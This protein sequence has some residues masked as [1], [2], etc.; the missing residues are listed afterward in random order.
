MLHITGKTSDGYHHLQS[1]FAFTEF[2]DEITIA[3]SSTNQVTFEGEF[4]VPVLTGE[5][6][7]SKA[8]AW[9]FEYFNLPIRHY[10]VCVVKNIPVAAGLGGGTSDAAAVL[11]YLFQ[12]DY[13][14]TDRDRQWDFVKSS[15]V[16]G[17]DVPVSLAFHLG[18]GKI[19]WV[20]G[21]GREGNCLPLQAKGI[22][23]QFVLV[24]PGSP[25]STAEVFKTLNSHFDVEIA[26]PPILTEDFLRK[27]RNILQGAA[28]KLM[29]DLMKIF[30]LFILDRSFSYFRLSG[31]GASCFVVFKNRARADALAE[32]IKNNNRGW[33]VKRTELLV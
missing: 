21:S 32:K 33:W 18:L 26:A 9:Y 5:D 1:V 12:L 11:A 28:L 17:S 4:A 20:D 2:G 29:P 19:F 24:N 31:S 13:A 15:G 30:M 7:I 8:M 3:S 6:S 22:S 25:L 23:R 14:Q 16:L 27:S 10:R